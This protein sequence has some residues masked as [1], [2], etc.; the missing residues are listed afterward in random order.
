MN[1]PKVPVIFAIS[2][3][4]LAG[5]GVALVRSWKWY[6]GL[7]DPPSVK[8]QVESTSWS[9]P[10]GTVSRDTTE[11]PLPRDQA[12]LLLKNPQPATP[13][14]IERGRRTFQ[15]YCF[16]CHGPEGHADGPV[17][18][19][20]ILRPP[21]LPLNLGRFTDGYL[22]A[23]IRNGGVIMPPYGYRIPPGKR[24][25]VVNYLRTLADK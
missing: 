8:L 18:D 9:P 19:K 4:V 17:A 11:P 20:M 5:G 10:A 24:W 14:S 1:L 7:I 23:T 25:D 15:T 21:D 2:L 13:D 16:V 22:Y 6:Q 3:I 12:A